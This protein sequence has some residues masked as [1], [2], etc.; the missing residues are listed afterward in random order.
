MD[1]ARGRLRVRGD[2]DLP[3]GRPPPSARLP[4][5]ISVL[6]LTC[7]SRSIEALR[8]DHLP[9]AGEIVHAIPEWQAPAGGGPA[10]AGQLA[11]L[12]GTV[13]FFTALG[14]D[15]LGHRSARVMEEM[16]FT[17]HV[18]FRD[19]PTRRGLV[20]IDDTGER[21]ITVIGERLAPARAMDMLRAGGVQ[22]DALVG[23]AA[24]PAEVYEHGDITPVPRLV[25]RTEGGKGGTFQIAGGSEQRFAAVPVPG[26]IVDRY[27]PGDSFAG[28]LTYGLG[29][30][31]SPEEAVG[32][33]ARCGA[34]VLT[35]AG[36]Y[37]TQLGLPE[38]GLAPVATGSP[39][40]VRW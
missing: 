15:E 20:H 3:L 7:A 27:G 33:A 23:S 17:L 1:G 39:G 14:D 30:G 8:V 35:G 26:P 19:E 4:Q 10:A 22:L 18:A 11:K 13:E 5:P 37:E 34:A 32:L 31:L 24:D 21:T 16:G 6:A 36:P 12:A 28:A 25:V 38:S 40:P 29:A 9:V 2:R